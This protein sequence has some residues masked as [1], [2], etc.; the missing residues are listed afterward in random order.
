MSKRFLT[1]CV[2]AALMLATAGVAAATPGTPGA[3]PE[4][5]PLAMNEQ[6]VPLGIQFDVTDNAL[7]GTAA[8]VA[9]STVGTTIGSATV[10]DATP[11]AIPLPAGVYVG[12]VG[13]AS[14]FAA[15]RR[16]KRRRL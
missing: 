2:A 10:A 15:W 11:A 8:G 1:G 13:L 16:F 4:R 5:G 6:P 3:S 12:L 9:S 7:G 14:T